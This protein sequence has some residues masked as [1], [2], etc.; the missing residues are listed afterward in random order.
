[1]TVAQ[2][3]FISRARK[4]A[5][6]LW[7]AQ[8]D[9]L[10]LQLQWNSLAY[11]DLIDPQDPKSGKN[12]PDGQGLN[13]GVTADQVGAVLFDTANAIQALLNAGHATNVARLL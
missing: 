2:D 12:L 3:Q 6:D 11:G 4:A 10:E 7:H 13:D 1:M 9:L 5:S 8:R